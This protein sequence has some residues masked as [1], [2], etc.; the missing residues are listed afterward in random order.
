MEQPALRS[1]AVPWCLP[2]A[3]V[4]EWGRRRAVGCSA[5]SAQPTL[6]NK[7]NWKDW[8]LPQGV[9]CLICRAATR[10]N[11]PPSRSLRLWGLYRTT[12]KPLHFSGPS[13]ANVPMMACPP[14]LIALVILS[15]YAVW[16][17]EVTIKW[18]TAR[19]CQRSKVLAGVQVVTSAAKKLMDAPVSPNARRAFSSAT[20]DMSRTEM[21]VK[22]FAER[23]A[24]KRDLPPPISMTDE[25]GDTPARAANS[26]ET[27]GS[28]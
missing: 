17:S 7:L 8:T 27:E 18:K 21:S 22:P 23:Q 13:R 9:S 1:I 25:E 2:V 24:A 19:S 28:S 15:M 12:G 4:I 11:S 3:G 16:S 10:V 5:L 26:S 20:G 14:V 6:R